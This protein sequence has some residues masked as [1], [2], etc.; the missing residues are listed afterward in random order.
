MKEKNQYGDLTVKIMSGPHGDKCVLVSPETIEKE[1]KP[2]MRKGY[3]LS[4]R[5]RGAAKGTAEV[6]LQRPEEITKE[7]FEQLYMRPA[8][9]AG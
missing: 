6:V 9:T 7:K 5:P 1:I 4:A 3:N 8:I 2:L